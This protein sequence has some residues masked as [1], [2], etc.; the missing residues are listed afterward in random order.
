MAKLRLGLSS[1]PVSHIYLYYDTYVCL[2]KP[3]SCEFHPRRRLRAATDSTLSSLVGRRF[4]HEFASRRP[5]S[6][7]CSPS[8]ARFHHAPSH[9]Q[10][11]R[12]SG[13]RVIDC[14]RPRVATTVGARHQPF[15]AALALESRT[16]QHREPP[17]RAGALT[18]SGKRRWSH[19]SNNCTDRARG[20]TTSHRSQARSATL[21]PMVAPPVDGHARRSWWHGGLPARAAVR[22]C[23]RRGGG[24]GDLDEWNYSRYDEW[25]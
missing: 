13:S 15:R 23:P 2:Q 6:L 16:T 14:T 22:H 5:H 4:A 9:P 11:C 17:V 3:R 24:R 12:R 19:D 20:S 18:P 1:L 8:E 10:P 25:R 21:T 7:A